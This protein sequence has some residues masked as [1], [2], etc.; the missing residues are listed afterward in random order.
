MGSGNSVMLVMALS[1]IAD[2]IGNDKVRQLSTNSPH[3]LSLPLVS[4][5]R[6]FGG[7]PYAALHLPVL[8]CLICRRVDR[9]FPSFLGGGVFL[10]F[11]FLFCVFFSMER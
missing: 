4:R 3:G 6:A 5:L 9:L 10:F 7:K 2:M 11:V 1:M 8:Y